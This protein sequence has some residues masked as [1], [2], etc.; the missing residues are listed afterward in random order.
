MVTST[1]GVVNGLLA[2]HATMYSSAKYA[3]FHA[4]DI[5]VSD[6]PVRYKLLGVSLQNYRS[7]V[8]VSSIHTRV[9]TQSVHAFDTTVQPKNKLCLQEDMV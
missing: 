2:L 6:E 5:E 4:T 3:L 9:L 8:A 7:A 1:A